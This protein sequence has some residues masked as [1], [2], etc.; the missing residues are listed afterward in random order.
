MKNRRQRQASQPSLK[1]VIAAA[2]VLVLAI[3]SPD[4]TT[5]AAP[6][7]CT[8]S[9]GTQSASFA[10]K[11]KAGQHLDVAAGPYQ[12]IL[13]PNEYGWRILVA[14]ADGKRLPVVTPPSGTPQPPV[15]LLGFFYRNAENSAPS[16]LAQGGMPISM[17]YWFGARAVDPELNPELVVPSQAGSA[18]AAA[19]EGP[20]QGEIEFSLL[21][22]GLA[23]L[24][25]GQRARMVY[26]SF[27][28]CLSWVS[29]DRADVDDSLEFIAEEIE[30]FGSCGLDL[31]RYRLSTL[32]A[33]RVLNMDIDGDGSHDHIAA[34][35]QGERRGLAICRAGTYLTLLGFAPEGLELGFEPGFLAALEAWRVLPRDVRG[36]GY[37]DE[38]TWPE[39]DGDIVLLERIEKAAQLLFMEKGKFAT[40]RIYRYVE[41]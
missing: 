30:T 31:A 7:A 14:S 34:V 11:V 8:P 37:E 33:P 9:A 32:F 18:A 29:P 40:L 25:P 13:E 1:R 27:S 24:E 17:R 39:A 15:G 10:G 19:P 16:P 5:A 41:P 22:Y 26:A 3:A 28:G 20:H 36:L 4:A 38:P 12:L 23:D 6:P 21:D 2:G 35:T